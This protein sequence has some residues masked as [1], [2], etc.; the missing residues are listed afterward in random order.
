MWK[1]TVPF[2]GR[3]AGATFI[4]SFAG[5]YWYRPRPD[6]QVDGNGPNRLLERYTSAFD[7][8]LDATKP[9]PLL[10]GLA[11]TI[12]IAATQLVVGTAM[13]TYGTV[14]LVKDEHYRHFV[15]MVTN[16]P[17]GKPLVTLSNHRTLFDDP[18][19]M[20][21]LLPWYIGVQPRY[22]R[23]GLCSQEYC[24]PDGLPGII[25]GY[26]GAGQVL[27]IWRGGGINQRLLLDFC[28]HAAAGEWCHL[29]PEAGIWQA[30]GLGGRGIGKDGRVLTPGIVGKLRWGVGKL[31][32]HAPETPVVIIF[33]HRGMENVLPQDP[34][35]HKTTVKRFFSPESEP[36]KVCFLIC[37][38]CP[39]RRS[40]PHHSPTATIL[41]NSALSLFPSSYTH[42][43]CIC[44]CACAGPYKIRRRGGIRRPHP[45]P[46]SRAWTSQEVLS[47]RARERHVSSQCLSR[48]L[49]LQ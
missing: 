31:I 1:G 12:S 35:T 20:S 28:R 46:R 36:L 27:P 18:G 3:A 41:V 2:L 44:I 21:C 23:W 34:V 5:A 49:G 19:I 33:A 11:R 4:A 43:T 37:L 29:F 30:P 9:P 8:A 14:T 25:Q 48:R 38:S 17:K 47:R 32:A 15:N 39:C 6:R 13:K 40:S 7:T 24:F 45:C 26:F 22:N 10:L 42:G 16:R